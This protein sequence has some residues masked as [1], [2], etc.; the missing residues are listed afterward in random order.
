M[1]L[2]CAAVIYRNTLLGRR[3]QQLATLQT[4]LTSVEATGKK[5]LFPTHQGDDR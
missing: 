5:L 4:S 3:E 2:R 1:K